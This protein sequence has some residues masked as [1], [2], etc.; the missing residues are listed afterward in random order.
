MTR[1]SYEQKVDCLGVVSPASAGMDDPT[2]GKTLGKISDYVLASSPAVNWKN[3]KT[4]NM[5]DRY[6]KR[7]NEPWHSAVVISYDAMLVAAD[8][9]ERSA[10]TDPKKV[11]DA[12]AQTS[13]SDFRM[14]GRG[15]I[16]F[17][18]QGDNINGILS[19]SQ[20]MNEKEQFVLPVDFAQTKFVFPVPKWSE[21][22][23]K[24]TWKPG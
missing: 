4:V 22:K 6:V 19:L 23:W 13:L 8:A 15:P 1:T 3:P 10:S 18:E 12:I 21:R 9:L 11:R 17:N 2:F 5:L 7:F 14:Y 24:R 20:W 16:R